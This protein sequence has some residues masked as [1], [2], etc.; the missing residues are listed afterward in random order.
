MKENALVIV[1][2]YIEE[3]RFSQKIGFISTNEK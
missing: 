1:V 2:V 3:I